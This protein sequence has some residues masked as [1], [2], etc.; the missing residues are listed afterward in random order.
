MFSE[1]V[2]QKRALK[3]SGAMTKHERKTKGF[4]TKEGEEG[5]PRAPW[6]EE[7]ARKRLGGKRKKR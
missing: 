7:S 4:P 5:K 3:R 6:R 2:M 1:D